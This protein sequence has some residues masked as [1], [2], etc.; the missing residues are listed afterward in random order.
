MVLLVQAKRTEKINHT[1]ENYIIFIQNQIVI[2]MD[3]SVIIKYLKR[4]GEKRF[5]TELEL[6]DFLLSVDNNFYVDYLKSKD[7]LLINLVTES[8]RKNNLNKMILKI[9][10]EED[11]LQ[12]AKEMTKSDS[13][14]ESLRSS[15]NQLKAIQNKRK[16]NILEL[17]L[18]I[19]MYKNEG[20]MKDTIPLSV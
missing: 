1:I 15:Y 9:D 12:E 4:K 2:I 16:Q 8:T 10:F 18:L 13:I 6:Y 3:E 20:N 11:N 19:D 17:I 14:F 7:K 5:K